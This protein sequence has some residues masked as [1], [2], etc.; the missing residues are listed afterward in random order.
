MLLRYRGSVIFYLGIIFINDFTSMFHSF[1]ALA[2]INIICSILFGA[3]YKVDDP[4][5][6]DLVRHGSLIAEGLNNAS[7]VALIP[8]LRYFP[9]EGIEKLKQG[10]AIRDAILSKKLREHRDTFDPNNIRDLTDTLISELSKETDADGN[11]KKLLSDMHMELILA[12]LLVAGPESTT[13]TLTWGIA[14]LVTCPEVQQKIAEER[15]RVI[16]D[17]QPC[18]KD[19]GSL[20]YFEATVQEIMRMSSLLPLYI[21]HK[22]TSDTMIGCERVAK[23]TQVWFNQWAANHDEREWKDPELFK[24]ER[25]LEKDGSLANGKHSKFLPFGAGGRVC[26]AESLAR[27]M[28]FLFLANIFYRYEINQAPEGTP[29][30]DGVLSITYSPKPYRVILERWS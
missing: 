15:K 22:A 29:Q 4:E 27:D 14:Y 30:F 26:I 20:P 19:R 10:V 11:T 1:T 2:V 12:D 6:L 25:W 3:R 8:W 23:D 9:S 17:R 21:P 7:A 28:V 18:L 5:F 13:T 24:P 16:G